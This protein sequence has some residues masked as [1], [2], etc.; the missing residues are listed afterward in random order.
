M[1]REFRR[2][3]LG[4]GAFSLD[5]PLYRTTGRPCVATETLGKF[6][7]ITVR[8]N[9]SEALFWSVKSQS[10]RGSDS[11][12]F[13]PNGMCFTGSKKPVRFEESA[14][15]LQFCSAGNGYTAGRSSGAGPSA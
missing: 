1:P 4:G 10:A 15:K 8:G 6:D 13:S 5:I 3:Q 2:V 11:C 14:R 7:L 9:D 12:G